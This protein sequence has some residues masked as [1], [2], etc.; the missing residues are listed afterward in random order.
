MQGLHL[1]ADFSHCACAGSLLLRAEPLASQVRALCAEAGLTVVGELA[2]EF[3]GGG[4]TLAILLAESHVTLHTWP[5][6]ASATMDV[7]VCNHTQ[8]NRQSARQ[9]AKGIVALLQ[10]FHPQMQ[11]IHRGL[12]AMQKSPQSAP[13]V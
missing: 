12:P 10:P 6:L 2:H 13:Q 8:D 3:P 5:E 11:E 1:I 9:V 7:F 4:F